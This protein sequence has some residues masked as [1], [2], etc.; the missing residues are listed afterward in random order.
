MV[1]PQFFVVVQSVVT[2]PLRAFAAG[3]AMAFFTAFG[4][5]G[6]VTL[7]GAISELGIWGDESLR[8]SLSIV[9]FFYLWGAMHFLLAARYCKSEKVL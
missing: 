8:Y 9:T 4:L 1:P 7:V 2:L 6:G 5:G 3:A